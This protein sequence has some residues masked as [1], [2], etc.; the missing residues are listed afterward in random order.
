MIGQVRLV[1][2]DVLLQRMQR[3]QRMSLSLSRLWL[4][5]RVLAHR[6]LAL[7]L[8]QM[9]SPLSQVGVTGFHTTLLATMKDYDARD[10][11]SGR[12]YMLEPNGNGWR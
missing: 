2:L 12:H 11:L 3:M 7:I 4:L 5:R 10:L 6:L 9:V 1:L 8:S